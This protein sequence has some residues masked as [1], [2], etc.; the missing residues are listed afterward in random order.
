[1]TRTERQISKLKD[2]IFKKISLKETTKLRSEILINY[3][4]NQPKVWPLS[5]MNSIH[6]QGSTV[7][8]RIFPKF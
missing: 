6:F 5:K 8:D 3:D 2:S 4:L 7:P 1:M